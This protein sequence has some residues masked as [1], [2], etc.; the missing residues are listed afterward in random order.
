MIDTMM[1]RARSIKKKYKNGLSPSGPK[2]SALHAVAD[3]DDHD[4]GIA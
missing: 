3:L 1:G 4:L 2:L